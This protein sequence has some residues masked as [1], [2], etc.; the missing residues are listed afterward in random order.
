MIFRHVGATIR[1]LGVD[2]ATLVVGRPAVFVARPEKENLAR[3]RLAEAARRAGF[4]DVRFQYEPIAAGLA[5]EAALARPE[6]ALIA[7]LVEIATRR[8]R[9]APGR[10]RTQ[11]GMTT[12]RTR[13][14]LRSGW[15][16]VG[17][18]TLALVAT[19]AA[20]FAAQGTG[21]PGLRAFIRATARTSLALFLLAF[22]ASA[23]R[24]AWPRSAATGWLLANRRHLGVSFA[25]SHLLHGAAIV[26]LFDGFAGVVA[27]TSTT[28]LALG[29]LGYVAVLALLATSFDAT[30]AWLGPRRW[31]RLHTVGVWWL[32]AIFLAT[33]VPAAV[34]HPAR[35]PFAALV[36]VALA[37]RLAY[38]P[39]AQHRPSGDS[40]HWASRSAGSS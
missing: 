1:R 10:D 37:V 34:D 33:F 7:D 25:V 40:S 3:K 39:G 23:L 6:T 36:V 16:V 28:T 14:S 24:R 30:A 21:E 22:T 8:W 11:A 38:R 32:W 4:V 27:H 13:R 35:A 15:P 9:S 19:G 26:A 5:Y 2:D 18:A 12:A 31:R 17:W 20:I 29:G